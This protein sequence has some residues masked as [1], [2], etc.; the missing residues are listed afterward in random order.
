MRRGSDWLA[1]PAL[2]YRAKFMLSLRD[3]GTAAQDDVA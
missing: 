3:D 1:F 2:K